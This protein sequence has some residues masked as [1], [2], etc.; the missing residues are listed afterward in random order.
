MTRGGFRKEARVDQGLA[1]IQ[2]GVGVYEQ[3][4]VREDSLVEALLKWARATFANAPARLADLNG[5]EQRWR[6]ADRDADQSVA[7]LGDIAVEASRALRAGS[8][9]A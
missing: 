9:N 5:W 1:E 4:D 8:A 3:L 2:V 6:S 7:E